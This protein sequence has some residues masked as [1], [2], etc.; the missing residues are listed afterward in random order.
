MIH[1]T[2]MRR[3]ELCLVIRNRSC[4]GFR[5]V[6][7]GLEDVNKLYTFF[8]S[9]FLIRSYIKFLIAFWR[10]NMAVT[11]GPVGFKEKGDYFYILHCL[12]CYGHLS[13]ICFRRNQPED[14]DRAL[15]VILKVRKPSVS[16]IDDLLVH[17]RKKG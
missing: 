1:L 10:P 13:L 3:C 5:P 6:R 14:R 16:S 17:H 12:I 8:R 11:I 4:S 2:S 15:D 9:R 7:Q